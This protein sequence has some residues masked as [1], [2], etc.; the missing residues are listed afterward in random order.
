M[1]QIMKCH[2]CGKDDSHTFRVYKE[3]RTPIEICWDCY[4]ELSNE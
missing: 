4:G 2:D 1:N 3:D